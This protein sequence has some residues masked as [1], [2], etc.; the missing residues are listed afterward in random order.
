MVQA[1]RRGC[2][3]HRNWRRR[4][5]SM[6]GP[7]LTSVLG[8]EHL[9]VR[10]DFVW[11]SSWPNTVSSQVPTLCDLYIVVSA[12]L[13]QSALL[14]TRWPIRCSHERTGLTCHPESICSEVQSVEE[15]WDIHSLRI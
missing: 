2:A 8:T 11:Q 10:L 14:R 12:S 4:L 7:V 3:G 9:E 15:Q 1:V 6:P 5:E 13:K